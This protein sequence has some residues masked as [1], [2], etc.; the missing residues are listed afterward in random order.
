MA[1]HLEAFAAQLGMTEA[2]YNKIAE[3]QGLEITVKA[4]LSRADY[5][6]RD[7]FSNEFLIACIASNGATCPCCGSIRTRIPL[8][9]DGFGQRCKEI[10]FCPFAYNGAE[11]EVKS[12]SMSPKISAHIMGTNYAGSIQSITFPRD[13]LMARGWASAEDDNYT[14]QYVE[15]IATPVA[16]AVK[17]PSVDPL[18]N[19]TEPNTETLPEENQVID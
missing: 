15:T 17:N 1:N 5:Q 9:N 19:K 10:T 11:W 6:K 12:S 18:Q 13:T 2:E 8:S 4:P 7:W 14:H 3:E 16:A